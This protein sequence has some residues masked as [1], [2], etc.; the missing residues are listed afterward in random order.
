MAI[1]PRLHRGA[2]RRSQGLASSDTPVIA[3]AHLDALREGASM[4]AEL[5]ALLPPNASLLGAAFPVL[6]KVEALEASPHGI[7]LGPLTPCLPERL[8]TKDRRIALAPALFLD[9][10]G[11]A[12]DRLAPPEGR[13]EGGFDLQL[14]GRRQ[15][16]SNNSWMHNSHRLVK[17]PSRCT[18]LMHPADA[19][20]RALTS[21]AKI[22]VSSRV[23]SIELELALSDEMMPGV[24]SIPHGWG[25]D[26]AGIQLDVARRHAGASINDL[27]DE[28]RLDALTGNAAFSGVPVR[29]EAAATGE[30]R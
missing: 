6:R 28:M 16:R 7:D 21:G 26:R 8:F 18:L 27:T 10:L 24:V 30:E 4:A 3:A 11:R 9:D 1:D 20:R 17:G 12:R 22:K 13:S 14:I 25:H 2:W 23:D 5:R 19:A 15:L 29:V